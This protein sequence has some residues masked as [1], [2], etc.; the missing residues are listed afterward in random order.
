MRLGLL[1][2]A[3][4]ENDAAHDRR[5]REIHRSARQAR[6]TICGCNR[7]CRAKPTA[8]TPISKSM[9]APAA[10]K[11]RTGPRCCS[12]CTRAGRSGTATSC[13]SSKKAKAR[14]PGIKSA[15][16]LV[17]GENAYGWLKTEAGVHR[18]VRISPF[19]AN[20]RRHTSFCQRHRLSGDRSVDRDRHSR[21]GCA[22]RRLSRVRRG[23]PARQQDRKRGA[24]HASADR[25]RRACQTNARSIRTARSAGTCCARGF[26]RSN[27]RRSRP[28]P[29]RSS[30]R[31]RDI[32][33]GH[34][35][36]SYVL[37]ALSAGEGSAHRRRKPL[38]AGCAGRRS[39]SL[40][41]AALA[42]AI[43]GKPKERSRIWNK[44]R[45][46]PDNELFIP[47]GNA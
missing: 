13:S 5:R 28:K 44:E 39:R 47:V 46:G 30:A 34:Q 40:H 32:G 29:A 1:E 23:R 36:R 3:E 45:L 33:W 16:L 17:K 21:Q 15:T 9:R 7:C 24:H 4:A 22:H 27:W 31:N 11:A 14:A 35:I 12:A 25:H 20:A 41:G 43:G 6:R 8:T 2:M 38:A 18:L 42:Q 37:A 19:D 26:T 10:P